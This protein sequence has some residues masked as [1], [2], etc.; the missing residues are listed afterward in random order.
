[1]NNELRA[2]AN[3]NGGGLSTA[4]T[5]AY[6]SVRHAL[7]KADPDKLTGGELARI[8]RKRGHIITARD[9]VDAHCRI[10]GRYPEWHHSGFKPKSAGGGMGRAYFYAAD[11]VDR[12]ADGLAKWQA[13]QAAD[14]AAA[15]AEAE[16]KRTTMVQGFAFEWTEEGVGRYR[17]KVKRLLA[18]TGPEAYAP[19]TFTA[20]DAA[21]FEAVKHHEGR[22]Y[23]G[24]DEPSM[25]DFDPAALAAHRKAVALAKR[26]AT[27]AAKK[28][29]AAQAAAKAERDARVA[30]MVADGSDPR[31]ALLAWKAAGGHHPAPQAVMAAKEVLG[32]SWGEIKSFLWP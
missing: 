7:A 20:C 16:R 26:R 2:I 6:T 19:R 10:M 9:L 18:Y 13:E 23:R 24:W 15:Q 4:V 27:I 14:R 12:M 31:A 25:G 22:I 1:M 8:L 5:G 21:H 30:A 32:W 28:E 29:A 17:R 11:V 3:E